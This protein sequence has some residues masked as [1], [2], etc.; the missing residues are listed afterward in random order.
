MADLPVLLVHGF[1]SSFE[2]NWREPG[3]V[4]SAAGG[5][6]PAGHRGETWYSGTGEEAGETA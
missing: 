6:S 5:R 2:R 1:A 4:D 3:W